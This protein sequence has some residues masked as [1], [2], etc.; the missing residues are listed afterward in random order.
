M[1]DEG[2][3]L[4]VLSGDEQGF[5][6]IIATLVETKKSLSI[7]EQE[8]LRWIIW[9]NQKPGKNIIFQA[10]LSPNSTNAVQEEVGKIANIKSSSK[11]FYEIFVNACDK[12]LYIYIDHQSVTDDGGYWYSVDVSEY[13][14]IYEYC[15]K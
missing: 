15:K 11:S 12:N 14:K 2:L 6:P 1:R 10:R 5:S 7:K 3:V 9:G 13:M 4:K 8:N